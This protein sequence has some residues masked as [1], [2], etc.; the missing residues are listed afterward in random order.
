MAKNNRVPAPEMMESLL[1]EIGHGYIAGKF[2]EEKV[3]I[4]VVMSATDE[5]LIKRCVRTIGQSVR[6]RNICRR[7]YYDTTNNN[8]HSCGSYSYTTTARLNA[9]S[10]MQTLGREGRTFLFT[11]RSSGNN[12]HRS[13][14]SRR[15]SSTATRKNAEK[16]NQVIELGQAN[17]CD[18][19]TEFLMKFQIQ[20][21][22]RFCKRQGLD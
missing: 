20:C 14:S 13:S 22:N 21:K 5:D 16:K 10:S 19:L 11:S 17:S 8:T 3:D 1:Q 18:Y 2:K 6:V 7:R 15:A 9:A 12:G 4:G